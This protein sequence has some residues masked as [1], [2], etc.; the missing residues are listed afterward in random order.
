MSDRSEDEE[1]ERINKKKLEE[2]L[3]RK[4]AQQSQPVQQPNAR[5]VELT[6]SNF[7]SEVSKYPVMVV[8][9]WAAW[10]GP[11][12]MVSPV[13]EQLAGEYAGKVAFGKL[14]VDENPMVSNTFGVQSIPTILVFKDGK[15]VDGLVGAVPKA[16]IESKLKPYLGG[17]KPDSVYG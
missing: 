3:M 17:K 8:D 10:C 9:F 7:F 2:L 11:C 6:D 1:I 5:P 12:R 14:N 4:K 15:Q 13:I 16:Y